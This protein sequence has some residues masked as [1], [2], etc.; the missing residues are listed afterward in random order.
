MLVKVVNGGVALLVYAKDDGVARKVTDVQ[1]S[2][3]S[4][5]PFYMGN[6]GAVGARFRVSDDETD[7]GETF[8]CILPPISLQIIILT[9]S[10]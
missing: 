9:K 10:F 1:T 8:T 4:C 5:G 7:A 6:K 2:W 3:T